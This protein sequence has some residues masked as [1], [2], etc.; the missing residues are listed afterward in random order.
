MTALVRR[1]RA[2]LDAG[3]TWSQLLTLVRRACAEQGDERRV[4]LVLPDGSHHVREVLS[5]DVAAGG[6]LGLVVWR[7]DPATGARSPGTKLLF[8]PPDKVL[9]LEVSGSGPD[10]AGRFGFDVG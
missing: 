3:V 6:L 2:W 9:R 10:D 8:V 1:A 5:E 7:D 4:L